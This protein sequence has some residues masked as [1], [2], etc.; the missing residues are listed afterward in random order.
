MNTNSR[1]NTIDANLEVI[2]SEHTVPESL[3]DNAAKYN[4]MNALIAQGAGNA[5]LALAANG[6]EERREYLCAAINRLEEALAI[7]NGTK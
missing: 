4:R 5:A 6:R 2:R 3:G 1:L 7:Q